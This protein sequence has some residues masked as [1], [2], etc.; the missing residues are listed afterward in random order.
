MSINERLEQARSLHPAHKQRLSFIIAIV[1]TIIIAL[2]WLLITFVYH[3]T[4]V[5]ESAPT[6]ESPLSQVHSIVV[7]NVSSLKDLG[8]MFK[9]GVTHLFGLIQNLLHG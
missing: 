5:A 6:L 8:A 3:P 1:G 7:A 9:S 4:P 2:F